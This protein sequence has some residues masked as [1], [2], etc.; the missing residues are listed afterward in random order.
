MKTQRQHQRTV[1]VPRNQVNGSW[2]VLKTGEAK[3]LYPWSGP[4]PVVSVRG[5]PFELGREHGS[6]CRERISKN[7]SDTWDALVNYLGC[8]KSDIQGDL[9]VYS[10][11][12]RACHPSFVKEMEGVASG[13]QV[14]YDDI[15]LLNSQ[16]NILHERGSLKGLE[17]LLCSSF[18]S[19][20]DGTR[21]GNLVMGHNDDGV[22]FTDQFLVLMDA[23]PSEGYRFATPIMP[24][25]LGY[26]T[27]VNESGFCAV[28]N[29]LENGPQPK[30]IRKGVPMWTIFRYLAQFVDNVDDGVDFIR[31]A[32]N[33]IAGSFLLGDRNGNAA[34]I[35]LTPNS[36]EVI[37]PKDK[38]TYLAMTNH[39][40]VE[41]IKKDL[42]LRDNP[43]S[44]YYRCDSL[45]RA[46]KKNFGKIDGS[47][48]MEIMSTHYD[49]SVGKDD[50]PSGNTPC[51]H[52]EF[53]SKFAGTCRSAVVEMGKKRLKMYVALGNPCT[54][55]WVEYDLN[56]NG[57]R[58]IAG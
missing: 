39:A 22:R 6:K 29:A 5:E 13:A 7:V 2:K 24:G 53:E 36:I 37:K 38:E 26:H 1:S 47:A 18:V 16:I 43:S 10:E 12:I 35:H 8:N 45:N 52:Y 28:G 44:T 20:G 34:L 57:R 30:E 46:I 42:L 58:K 50:H 49:A 19:W 56:Y 14:T 23:T 21:N 55:S 31:N 25:Y 41:R 40:L 48:G 9:A 11:K 33:G 3:Y 4:I 17:S 54:A 32:D 27:V 51:R 15:V